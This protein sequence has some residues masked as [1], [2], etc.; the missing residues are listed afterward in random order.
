MQILLQPSGRRV[1]FKRKQGLFSK[2]SRPNRYLRAWAVGSW[3]SGSERMGSGSN[4]IRWPRI[5][6]FWKKGHVGGGAS[7]RT[8][9]APDSSGTHRSSPYRRSWGRFDRALG[10]GNQVC[11]LS[12]LGWV[13]FGWAG[14]SSFSFSFLF[15]ISFQTQLKLFELKWNL[16]SNPYTIKQNKTCTSMNATTSLT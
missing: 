7:R 3:S 6:W 8:W 4:L 1:D 14:L 15:P 2:T 10:K 16:N 5:G 9:G 13:G 11:G 12:L